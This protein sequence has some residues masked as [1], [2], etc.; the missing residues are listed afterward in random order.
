M[1][2]PRRQEI[3]TFSR[4]GYHRD[5]IQVASDIIT[6]C[7]EPKSMTRVMQSSN[8]TWTPLLKNVKI[9]EKA[10]F[11][12]RLEPDK[13]RDKRT[14]PLMVSTKAGREWCEKVHDIYLAINQL[15]DDTPNG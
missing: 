15:E 14:K 8:I 13:H 5:R 1:R 4:M 7:H 9:L 10:G 12:T 6:A 11:I 2:A 3:L